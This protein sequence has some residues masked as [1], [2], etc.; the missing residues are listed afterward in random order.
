MFITRG[1]RYLKRIYIDG[2]RY[3]ERL[4]TETGGSRTPHWKSDIHWVTTC[5]KS[6]SSGHG[7]G[8]CS[9]V[10]TLK[11]TKYLSA[12]DR[13]ERGPGDGACACSSE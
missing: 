1:K 12:C 10:Q 2:C 3:N 13:E 5:S 11:K 7:E 9:P 8:N 4:N 6:R